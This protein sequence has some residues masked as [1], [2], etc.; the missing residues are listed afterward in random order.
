MSKTT[1]KAGPAPGDPDVLWGYG[2]IGAAIGLKA[3]Q[4]RYL[5]LHSKPPLP[6]AN[7]NRRACSTRSSLARHFVRLLGEGA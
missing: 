4:V 7:I 5:H 2:Q 3:H 6:I 1:K